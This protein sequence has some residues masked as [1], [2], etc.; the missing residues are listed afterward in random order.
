MGLTWQQIRD[1]ALEFQVRWANAGNERAEA[2]M[3]LYEF[4]R[5]FGVDQRRVATFE[6]KVHP[7]SDT[8]GYIDMLWPGRILVEMKSKGKSL[9]RA[10]EQAKDYAF[11][12][13]SDDDLPEF[14][15]V[16]DFESIRL[17]RQTTA[18]LW[19]FKTKDLFDHVE[20]FSV[21]TESAREF[22]YA[23]DKE[24]NIEA[25]YK[26]GSLH[27]MLKRSGYT[28]HA[29]EICLVRL[30][31]CLYSDHSGIFNKR[32]FHQY[33]NGS[34]DSGSDLSGKLVNLFDVLKTPI[35]ERQSALTNEL[36]AFP[37]VNGGLFQEDLRPAAF[38]HKMRSLLLECCEFDWS[39]ISPAI[40][41][42]MFQKVMN[43]DKRI[44]LKQYTPK[45]IIMSVIRPL[46]LD[47]LH[48]ELA[49]I[50][51]NRTQLD[52]FRKKLASMSFVDPACGCGNFLMVIYQELRLLELETIRKIYPDVSKVPQGFSLEDEIH[53]NIRQFYG[54]E[55]EEF[56]ARIAQ[57]GM[58]IVDHKMNNTAAHIFG[59]PLHT[60]PL[61]KEI[62]IRYGSTDGNA[63]RIDWR[64]V[65]PSTLPTYIVGNPEYLGSQ[66]KKTENQKQD[67]RGVA[68]G[69]KK[70]GSLDYV[71]GW[72]IKAAEL[73]QNSGIRSA[74]VSTSSISQGVHASILWQPL[75]EQYGMTI[76]FARQSFEWD[77]EASNRAMVQCVIIG[78]SS[79][80]NCIPKILF[81]ESGNRSSPDNIDPY[82][83]ARPNCFLPSRPKP[84]CPVPIMRS[85]NKPIDKGNYL[86]TKEQMEDFIAIEPKSKPFFR[87][88]CGGDEYIYKY[89]RYILFLQDCPPNLLMSMPNVMHRIEAVRQYRKKSSDAGTVKLADSPMRFHVETFP[90]ERFLL[91]PEVSSEK[92]KYIPM[93]FMEPDALCLYSNLTRLVQGA[94]DYH[95]GVL[96]SSLHMLWTNVVCG[97]LVKRYRYSIQIVYNNFPW[98]NPTDTQ[99]KAIEDAAKQVLT[100]KDSFE[101]CTYH[102]LYNNNAMPDSLKKAHFRLDRVVKAAYGV[103][104]SA[105]DEECIS[106]LFERYKHISSEI[107]AQGKTR[108]RKPI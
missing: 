100:I 81:N 47:D 3:F 51:S 62:H 2:Q 41:G 11:S 35:V 95:F 46:F 75:I 84:I 93:G 105:S 86:F 36:L 9:D 16:C 39:D 76:D 27:D 12:I 73:M 34:S 56:P 21:L 29:L 89:R 30:L 10:Y 22:D 48:E 20:R 53:V 4:L 68:S 94:T 92:R 33:I 96:T 18:Q 28:G 106:M 101:D 108:T 19:E 52:Q 61:T 17:Y 74:F 58:W 57:V 71:S 40:F 5:V 37:Y 54:I 104:S 23:V 15:M 72:F 60:I 97:R 31:F 70:A 38:D 42:A 26:M 102:D 55:I 13:R 50:G 7:T 67:L 1:N 107:D 65:I 45:N 64:S 8:S 77:N 85:G 63:L 98:P 44:K 59:K 82:L 49:Q 90:T 6:E 79:A 32:Q 78:F 25:A 88:W 66:K 87:E 83:D 99:K 80:S 24:L 14:I 43:P 91:I 69:W 103:K